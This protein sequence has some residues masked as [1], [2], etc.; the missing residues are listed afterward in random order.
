MKSYI[1]IE[2]IVK[3][4]HFDH[5]EV[6]AGALGLDRLVKWVH[7]VEVVQIKNL[8]RGHE[9]ILTTGLGFKDDPSLFVQFV[10]QLID[11]EAAGLCIEIGTNTSTIPPDVIEIANTHQF[12][13]IV[14]NQEVPFVEITQ[15]IHSTLIN[16]QYQVI[17]DLEHYSQ[18][19]NKKLL[20]ISEYDEI[21]TFC[22]MYL[23]VQVVAR[24]NE[25]DLKFYPEPPKGRRKQLY[26]LA[27]EAAMD[28]QSKVAKQPVMLLGNQYAEVMIISKDRD[29][30]E[31]DFLI[32]DRTVTALA[33][34]LLRTMYVEERKNAEESQ[35]M[36]DWLEGSH[37]EAVIDEHLASLEP[38]LKLN[39][40]VVCVCKYQPAR[41][42]ADTDCT[43]LKLWIRTVFEQY[44]F[45]LFTIDVRQDLVLILGNKRAGDDW[46]E[47]AKEA[48]E[49]VRAQEGTGGKSVSSY[50]FGVGKYIY[51]LED[52]NVSY[53]TAREALLL[54]NRAHHKEMSMFYDDLHLYRILS[55][56]HQHANL[57]EIV[58]DY[59][60][61]VIEYDKRYNGQLLET[62]KAYLT[63]SGSKQETAKRLFIVRQTL[64]HRIE[65]LEKL[66]GSDFME[67]EKRLALEFMLLAKDYLNVEEQLQKRTV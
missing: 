63:C 7:V 50:R 23:D 25:K 56:I 44:G 16:K 33:Q 31:Y 57:D 20:E 6:V 53:K 11:C 35:W 39:G 59:L 13:I 64:Y 48:F 36:L 4:K 45:H 8:L 12:P 26:K 29:L 38:G 15:D 9:L 66:L 51:Q 58:S 10:K 32:L 67:A 19:L 55:V 2:E 49:R 30:T 43:Y 65:K 27:E 46:K 37:R 47:R 52:V 1:S 5:I 24:F 60:A 62:L 34:Q 42:G 61:P 54:T 21:L 18:Q 3:R 17:S 14:F 41:H 22:Q 40:A 28:K